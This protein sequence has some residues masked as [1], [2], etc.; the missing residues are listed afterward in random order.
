MNRLNV[1]NSDTEQKRQDDAGGVFLPNRD[2]FSHLAPALITPRSHLVLIVSFRVPRHSLNS[3]RPPLPPEGPFQSQ[4][5]L[6]ASESL[7]HRILAQAFQQ[8]QVQQTVCVQRN[9]L[10]DQNKDSNID[11]GRRL[12]ASGV[13]AHLPIL[14]RLTARG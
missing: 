3:V 6:T 1:L 9:E 7:A 5:L 2:T 12:T 8:T 13:I 4:A 10:T 14:P 11:C